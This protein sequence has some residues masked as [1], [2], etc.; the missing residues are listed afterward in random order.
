MKEE[1]FKA[2]MSIPWVKVE[3]SGSIKNLSIDLTKVYN[4]KN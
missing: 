2:A 4:F 1:D 3:P